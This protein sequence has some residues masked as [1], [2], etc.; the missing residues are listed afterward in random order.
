MNH[1]LKIATS[2]MIILL[3]G[4]SGCAANPATKLS[5]KENRVAQ[6]EINTLLR[7][8]GAYVGDNSAVGNIIS[9]LP[10]NMYNAGFRLDTD[11]EPYGITVNYQANQRLG[12]EDY[13]HFWS[14]NKPE[15]VLEKNAVV[16]LS[17]IH[18]ASFVQFNVQD[19]AEKS[20]RFTRTDL[21]QK[22]GGALPEL[23][24]D[25]VSLKKLLSES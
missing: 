13:H 7:Y 20:C 12:P 6:G 15:A 11:R 8:K 23:F 5:P 2:A 25:E 18:N 10:A 14:Q 4:L 1:K 24:K 9:I 22:Y 21:E 17:L 19:I 3:L 16:L